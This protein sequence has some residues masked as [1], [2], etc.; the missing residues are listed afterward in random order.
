MLS[1]PFIIGELALGNLRQREVILA[2]LRDLPAAPVANDAE[3]L[4]FIAGHGLYGLGI[5][6]VD[7]HLLAACLLSP[8]TRLWTRDERLGDAARRLEIIADE[9]Q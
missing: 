9:V 1:H 2:A 8:G 5:G 4:I 7:A 3:M 6:Y